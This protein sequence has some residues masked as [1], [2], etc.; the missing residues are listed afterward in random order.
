VPKP[1]LGVV[2]MH[3]HRLW[4]FA[5]LLHLARCNDDDPEPLEDDEAGLKL[6]TLSAEQMQGMHAKI[7]SNQDGKV[8][9]AEMLHFATKVRRAIAE[10]DVGTIMAEMDSDRD[11]KLSLEELLKDLES[12]GAEAEEGDNEPQVRKELETQKFK[13]ADKNG[14]GFLDI[15]ELPPVFYPETH[16]DILAVAAGHTHRRKDTDSNGQLSPRE[17][18]EG[19]GVDGQD[20]AI[21]KEED[22]DFKKLDKDGDGSLNV[23]ELK[24][25]ES[26]AFHT[27][28]AMQKL[29]D[30]ADT[31]HDMHVT[32]EELVNA[33]EG[34]AGTDAQYNLMEWA[35]HHE[36]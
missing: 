35:E 32:A 15:E 26:G 34:I 17:F 21:S 3:L 10:K 5:I 25:W 11:G 24:F 19:D 22:A 31:D 23:E 13:I 33:R 20:I 1:I 9:M 36:L 29:F 27:Q 12:W 4:K 6:D 30:L 8:S 7:D 16:D 14:D 18:W 2:E 28:D